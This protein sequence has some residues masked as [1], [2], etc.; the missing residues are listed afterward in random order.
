[1]SLGLDKCAVY[2]VHR[3][4][5]QNYDWDVYLIDKSIIKSDSSQ[6]V[7][8]TTST[9]LEIM[10]VEKAQSRG[11]EHAPVPL[12][13]YT[14]GALECSIEDLHDLNRKFRKIININHNLHLAP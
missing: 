14:F 5:G 9:D 2:H 12:I 1:M 13:A 4:K 8:D 6:Q 10:S 11:Y 3:R 7:Q